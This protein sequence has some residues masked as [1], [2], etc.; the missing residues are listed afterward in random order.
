MTL[1]DLRG[2]DL[3]SILQDIKQRVEW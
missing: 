3:Q 1:D 2:S